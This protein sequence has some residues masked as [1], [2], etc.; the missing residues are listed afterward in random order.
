ME[1][2]AVLELNEKKSNSLVEKRKQLFDTLTGS[3]VSKRARL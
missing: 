1:A 3:V 2:S